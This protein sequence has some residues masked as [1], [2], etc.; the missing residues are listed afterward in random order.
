MKRRM[1]LT[2]E[3]HGHKVAGIFGDSERLQACRDQLIESIDRAADQ[4]E[5]LDS[6]TESTAWALEPEPRGIWHTL[7][8]AH[9]WLGL[10][11]AIAALPIY[12]LMMAME[13]AFVVGNPWASLVLLVAFCTTGG[14]LLGGLV[15][16]RPDHALY[17]SRIKAAL[18]RDQQVLVFHAVDRR[19][20]RTAKECLDLHADTTIAT[21]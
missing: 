8:R 21:L 11:G 10:A 2:G 9:L 20:G 5:V 17:V 7:V 6:E 19:Q 14:A 16:I 12:A 13:V 18:D 1:G 4:I 15:T 3:R